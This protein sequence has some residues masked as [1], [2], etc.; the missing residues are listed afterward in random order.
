MSKEQLLK[1]VVNIE[2]VLVADWEIKEKIIAL[3]L[4]LSN[5]FMDRKIL[6]NIWEEIKMFK[7][8]EFAEEK[9]MEKGKTELLLKQ[10]EKK[11]KVVP[12]E[13]KEKIIKLD[14]VAVDVLA[15]DILDMEDIT[16]LKK[17][18]N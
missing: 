7:F 16:E 5:K 1:E 9:G 13:Y 6:E 12:E 4:V 18:L 2:K 15:M 14:Q 3:T 11:F 10:I 8:I 17:Y